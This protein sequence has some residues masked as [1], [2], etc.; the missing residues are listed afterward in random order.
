L[1]LSFFLL[2]HTVCLT[3]TLFCILSVSILF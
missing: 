3:V 2:S 1:F